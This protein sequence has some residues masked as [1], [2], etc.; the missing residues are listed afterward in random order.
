MIRKYKI[1]LRQRTLN[2]GSTENDFLNLNGYLV[3][4]NR[5]PIG[6]NEIVTSFD[7]KSYM[8]DLNN[9][10]VVSGFTKYLKDNTDKPS[11][12]NI[13]YDS[14][15]L[16][17][18]INDYYKRKVKLNLDPR[19]YLIN[20]VLSGGT[21]IFH[22]SNEFDLNGNRS[23]K[24]NESI[25]QQTEEESYYLQVSINRSNREVFSGDFSKYVA[26]CVEDGVVLTNCFVN[27]NKKDDPFEFW[28]N[29]RRIPTILVG[30]E[31]AI[32]RR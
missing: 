24:E 18:L 16:A 7:V 13:F 23:L 14:N 3:H 26:D 5:A 19:E 32:I 29:N 8:Q 9:I 31:R 10:S 11:F 21:A 1:L 17:P 27:L 6:N 22:K 20:Y 4:P 12:N 2:T 25:I 28:N 15:K 30:A